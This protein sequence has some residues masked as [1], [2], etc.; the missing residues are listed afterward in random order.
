MTRGICS[1][2]PTTTMP[3]RMKF[4]ALF[5]MVTRLCDAGHH[6][7]GWDPS[8]GVPKTWE[9]KIRVMYEG[10]AYEEELEQDAA[11]GGHA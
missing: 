10:D 9:G 8:F 11:A 3:P 1:S 5:Q 2:T 7:D 4:A 6:Q